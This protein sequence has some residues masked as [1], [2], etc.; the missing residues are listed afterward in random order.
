M[1]ILCLQWWKLQAESHDMTLASS[2]WADV[3]AA[4]CQFLLAK[5]SGD[6]VELPARESTS[7][8]WTHQFLSSSACNTLATPP[9]G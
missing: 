9:V 7:K 5:A 2:L 8:S 6:V 4:N 3:L 1:E